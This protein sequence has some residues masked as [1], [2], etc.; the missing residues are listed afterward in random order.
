MGRIWMGKTEGIGTVLE[1]GM[2]IHGIFGGSKWSSLCDLEDSGG[3]SMGNKNQKGVGT[4]L[5]D[6]FIY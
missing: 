2:T 1:K 3:G 4:K 5:I 6:C